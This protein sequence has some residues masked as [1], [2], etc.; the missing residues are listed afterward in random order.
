M[1][2]AEAERRRGAAGRQAVEVQIHRAAAAG[3][4]VDHLLVQGG[5]HRIG[6]ATAKGASEG[7]GVGGDAVSTGSCGALAVGTRVVGENQGGSRDVQCTR[8]CRAVG[9]AC[10]RSRA[11]RAELDRVGA[12]YGQA[13]QEGLGADAVAGGQVT[14]RLN[15]GRAADDTRTTQGATGCDS[16]SARRER[17]IAVNNKLA[18]VDRRRARV[19]VVAGEN[20]RAGVGFG[21]ADLG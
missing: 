11:G 7:R 12:G 8:H 5:A 16:D 17:L 13:I 10:G 1:H 4:A 19:G 2:I 3:R 21:Q 15:G 6:D 20:P 18:E 14:A 9:C